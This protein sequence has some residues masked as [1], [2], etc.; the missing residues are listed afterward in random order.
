MIFQHTLPQ[1][2]EGKKTQTRRLAK[3]NEEAIVSRGNIKAVLQSGRKKWQVGGTY[4]IQPKRGGAAIGRL[5][6]KCIRQELA[7]HISHEDALQE[8]FN[9]LDEFIETWQKIHGKNSLENAVW[10][11]EFEVKEIND[12]KKDSIR[13]HSIGQSL[14]RTSE[15][16]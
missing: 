5:E 8:G 3:P 13:F 10:V 6:I 11:L 2:I 7:I 9:D 15:R 14:P 12:R 1:I 4:A 16:W